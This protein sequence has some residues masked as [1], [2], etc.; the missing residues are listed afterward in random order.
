MESRMK[1]IDS[2]PL[3]GSLLSLDNAELG[4]VEG[5]PGP[6]AYLRHL[7]YDG[8]IGLPAIAVFVDREGDPIVQVAEADGSMAPVHVPL[9]RVVEMV[10]GSKD[11]RPEGECPRCHC[12]NPA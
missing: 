4:L 1:V 8:N 7:D 6:Y 12:D 9:R 11:R 10:R 2:G 3:R 5:P